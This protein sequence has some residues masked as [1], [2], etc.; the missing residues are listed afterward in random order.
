MKLR[1]N[2]NKQEDYTDQTLRPTQGVESVQLIG[3]VAKLDH[4]QA[5]ESRKN[6]GWKTAVTKAR[7]TKRSA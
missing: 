1:I 2:M 5:R 4:I 7:R 3:N 6:A